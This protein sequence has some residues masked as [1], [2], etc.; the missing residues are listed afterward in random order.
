MFQTTFDYICELDESED[1]SV[2]RYEFLLPLLKMIESEPSFTD[3]HHLLNGEKISYRIQ[4]DNNKF[5]ISLRRSIPSDS[6]RERV[7][8]RL[9]SLYKHGKR[10]I[11]PV[12][13][14]GAPKKYPITRKEVEE[15]LRIGNNTTL[16]TE[17]EIITDIINGEPSGWFDQE[18]DT[19][20]SNETLSSIIRKTYSYLRDEELLT[21]SSVL[22][23]E[24]KERECI[25]EMLL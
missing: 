9:Y 17:K 15:I 23:K 16:K 6:I 22:E 20:L 7:L 21:L 19:L 14:G 1:Q 24:K 12:P 2:I 13:Q 4:F 11:F 18:I 10:I 3:Y 8:L 5:S 25:E